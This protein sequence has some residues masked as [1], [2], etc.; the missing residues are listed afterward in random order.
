M[1]PPVTDRM[2]QLS[3][4]A[5]YSVPPLIATPRGCDSDAVVAASPSLLYEQ[6]PLPAT[7]LIAPPLTLRTRQFTV[8]A[9]Y[10][11]PPASTV[12]PPG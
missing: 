11:S 12:T 2:R 6:K 10:T 1:V 5:M 9:M 4:S 7:V 3:P 8:S